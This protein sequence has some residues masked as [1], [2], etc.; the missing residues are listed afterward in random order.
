MLPKTPAILTHSFCSSIV[1]ATSGLIQ[2]KYTIAPAMKTPIE[3]VWPLWN[4]A[5]GGHLGLN[6]CVCDQSEMKDPT[7]PARAT[8][9][10]QRRPAVTDAMVLEGGVRSVFW[11]AGFA[12]WRRMGSVGTS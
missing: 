12:F 9:V 11:F 2:V 3:R 4:L 8:R 5:C 1:R 7:E 6:I 10:K